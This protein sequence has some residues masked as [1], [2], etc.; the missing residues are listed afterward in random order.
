M[1]PDRLAEALKRR[2]RDLGFALAGACPAV[3]ARGASRLDEWLARG[4]AGDMAWIA[5]R[6]E[7]YAHPRH[8]LDGVRSIL[9]LGL[10]Y[11]TAEP[12]PQALGQGRVA[13]YAWGEADYHDV[14][15]QRLHVLADYLRELEPGA[16][17]RGVVDTAPLLEREFAQLAGLGWIGKNTLL[18]NKYAGSYFF[19]A[20]LLTDAEL[21]YDAPHETD[22][23]GTCTACLDACPTNAFPQPFVLDASRC[24]SYLT[25]EHRG[26]LPEHLRSGIGDW[27]FGCDVCQEVCPW[28]SP[29]SKGGAR[30]GTNS[31]VDY[32]STDATF[33]PQPSLN[34]VDLAKLFDLTEDDFRRRFR[35]TPLWRAHRRGLLR[36]AAI[37]LGN[38]RDH[39]ALPA[40]AKGLHD[41]EPLV[42]AASAWALRQIATPVASKQLAGSVP[43]E[44]DPAALLTAPTG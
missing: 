16:A 43:L 25:I 31:S 1:A 24:I 19:L 34:S 18:L 42:R 21:A 44:P 9:M 39:S 26:D 20:A 13:R 38:Q 2:A 27:L 11:R 41:S 4:Y 12:A 14:I 8:L 29:P 28:N 33:N 23:C 7:A 37:V 40:L 32:H 10:A 30:G 17:T 3:A 15:R 5:D 22:H 36:N 6:R 35:H